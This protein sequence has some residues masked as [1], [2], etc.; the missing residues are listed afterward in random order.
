M[1]WPVLAELKSPNKWKR[2][3]I[4]DNSMLD[5]IICHPLAMELL[6]YLNNDQSEHLWPGAVS[7]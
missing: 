7:I 4:L 2:R 3:V 1:C 5:I 6:L